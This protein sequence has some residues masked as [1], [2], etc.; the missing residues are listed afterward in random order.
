MSSIPREI[1]GNKF[2]GENLAG[3]FS[4]H[5]ILADVSKSVIPSSGEIPFLSLLHFSKALMGYQEK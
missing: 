1:D 4:L 5:S 3:I 2:V